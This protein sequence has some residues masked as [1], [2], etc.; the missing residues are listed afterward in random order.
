MANVDRHDPLQGKIIHDYD[1]IEEA[2]NGL[3]IWLT[4]IFFG[5]TAFAVMYWFYYEE[6]QIGQEPGQA[7]AAAM[8]AQEQETPKVTDEQ[9]TSLAADPSVVAEGKKIFDSNCVACHG[10]KAQ[11]K[12]GPNL[13]DSYWIHGGQ[14]TDI[15]K[16]ITDGVAT[17]GMPTWG[18]ILGPKGVQHV[19][20]YVLSLR[21]TNVPGKAPQGEKYVP[22][23]PSASAKPRGPSPPGEA[24]GGGATAQ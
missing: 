1:G 4:A 22:S 20:A 24:P 23:G 9:L 2:D 11:G 7:Y 15:Y 3:P 14:P 12:I 6:Y 5:T 16:T 21:D 18:P 13:T 19:E 8:A 17:K 10:D